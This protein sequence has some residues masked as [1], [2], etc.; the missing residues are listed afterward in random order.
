MTARPTAADRV[1]ALLRE[2]I[3]GGDLAAGSQHS[4]YRL[5]EQLDVSRTPVREAVLRLADLGLVEVERNRGIRIRGVTVAD[6]R[7][8]FELRLLLEVP[9]AAAAARRADAI[10]RSALVT[11]IEVTREHARAGREADFTRVD[12]DFHALIASASQNTRLEAEVAR[13]RDSIQAR[14]VSTFGRSRPLAEVVAEHAPVADAIG[15]G[16]PEQA[17][18]AMADHLE[19]TGTLLMG[20]VAA[21]DEVVDRRWAAPVRAAVAAAGSSML[22]TDDSDEGPR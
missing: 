15:R 22:L 9:A 12:R 19:H 20:Q 3:V 14:G 11:N 5:S 7:E 17:A 16:E 18:G 10:L 2:R 1:F 6:V 4:I 13:L 8:V 21:R